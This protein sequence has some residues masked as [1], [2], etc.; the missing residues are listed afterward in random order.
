MLVLSFKGF[1]QRAGGTVTLPCTYGIDFILQVGR[2]HRAE[3]EGHSTPC[4]RIYTFVTHGEDHLCRF[5]IVCLEE[6]GIDRIEL[7][8]HCQHLLTVGDAFSVF[9]YRYIGLRIEVKA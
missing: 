1:Q 9:I 8:V 6:I 5:V 7:V 2:F 4:L 3:Q